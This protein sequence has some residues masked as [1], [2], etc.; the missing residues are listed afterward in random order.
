MSVVAAKAGYSIVGHIGIGAVLGLLVGV[1]QPGLNLPLAFIVSCIGFCWLALRSPS[2]W[3]LVSASLA[4]GATSMALIF[5]GTSSWGGQV[6]LTM[7]AAGIVFWAL[8][9]GLWSRWAVRNFD[10]TWKLV[11]ATVAFSSLWQECI[12][13]L[14]LPFRG[15]GLA[16]LSVP[17]LLA[18]IRLVGTSVVEGIVLGICL[19]IALV[20]AEADRSLW[21]RIRQVSVLFGS[22]VLILAS[23]SML[24]HQTAPAA[25]ASISVGIPQINTGRDYYE[26]RLTNR[27]AHRLFAKR[28]DRMVADLS[29]VDLLVTSETYDGRFGLLFPS[30]RERWKKWSRDHANTVLVSSFLVDDRGHRVNAM[31]GISEGVWLGVHEKID[32]APFGEVALTAG[33]QRRP[34]R[35]A[36]G[37]RVGIL[38]CNEALLRHSGR[39]LVDAGADLLVATVNAVSFGSSLVVFEHLGLARLR[40]LEL[41]RDMIWASN[42]GPSGV[43]DR[44]GRMAVMAPFRRPVAV[45]ANAELYSAPTPVQR[46]YWA[47]AVASLLVLLIMILRFRRHG[48]S[49]HVE[50]PAWCNGAW[51]GLTLGV[52]GI[53]VSI[54]VVAVSSGMVEARSGDPL[55]ARLAVQEALQGPTMRADRDPYARFRQAPSADIGAI[56]YFLEYYGADVSAEGMSVDLDRRL[57]VQELAALLERSVGLRTRTLAVDPEKLPRVAALTRLADGRL[58]VVNQPTIGGTVSAFDAATGGAIIT[59]EQLVGLGPSELIIPFRQQGPANRPSSH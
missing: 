37:A 28:F 18:G 1:G 22:G 41:G 13:L 58:V 54:A 32:L 26:G 2:W 59:A 56:S 39:E 10:S 6:V 55:R 42:A 33:T 53:A 48:G 27:T 30:F 38:I 49:G 7:V 29:S 44:W 20:L 5:A 52:S 16:L 24:A 35:L 17:D 4:W 19:G 12:D 46:L 34:L 25:D 43:I 15:A 45:H 21:C 51:R 23:L 57:S 14:G 36:R 40:A 47:P 8:P 3:C 11:I 9:I 50:H 31:A